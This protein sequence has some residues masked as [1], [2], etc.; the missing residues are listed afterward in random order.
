MLA[1]TELTDQEYERLKIAKAKGKWGH[2]ESWKEL[3][4]FQRTIGTMKQNKEIGKV[5]KR[6]RL[7]EKVTLPYMNYKGI[8][9]E[10]DD[11]PSLLKQFI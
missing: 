8:P 11:R 1:I 6:K 2:L 9:F 7:G 3:Y 5:A 4:L 10:V